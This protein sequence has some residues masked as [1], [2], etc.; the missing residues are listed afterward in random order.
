MYF[1]SSGVV[2][3]NAAGGTF[4]LTRGDFFGE[5][6]LILD[7]P[8]QADVTARSYCQLLAL[9]S[10]DFQALLRSS[11]EI[12]AQIDKAAAERARLNAA[13]TQ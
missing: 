10:K 11:R 5:M 6:A 12:R 1:I 13:G 9:A 3:V 4:L 7:Q 2:E 8:R